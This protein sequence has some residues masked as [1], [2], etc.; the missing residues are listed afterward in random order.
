MVETHLEL[1]R[2]MLREALAWHREG[3]PRPPL[4]GDEL[5]AELGIEPGPEMGRLLDELRAAAF[6]G[7]IRGRD[8]AIELARQLR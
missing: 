5:Q 6:A 4:T 3:Q 8:E 1:A 7:E 2:E